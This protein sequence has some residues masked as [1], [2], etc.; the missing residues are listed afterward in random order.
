MIGM[1]TLVV[2]GAAIG[3]LWMIDTHASAGDLVEGL[4]GGASTVSSEYQGL[5]NG[6]KALSKTFTDDQGVV[7]D[8]SG[9]T[10]GA[11][12]SGLITDTGDPGGSGVQVS[13]TSAQPGQQVQ[14]TAPSCNSGTAS[15]A[16]FDN[17][18]VPL[19]TNSNGSGLAGTAMINT[20]AQNG[21]WSVNV[22]CS[23]GFSTVNNVTN[24]TVYGAKGGMFPSGPPK[25]GGGGS[26]MQGDVG[27]TAGGIALVVA[28]VSYG[29]WTMSR[30]GSSGTHVG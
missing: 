11:G 21:Q 4:K 28:G 16:V 17:V 18:S 9:G 26:V 19:T 15:S 24:I 30:R 7:H 3:L 23:T 25:A 14:I 2:A 20:G 27:M 22:T 12:V 5:Q 8:L 10:D 13:P 6:A 29:L 1:K